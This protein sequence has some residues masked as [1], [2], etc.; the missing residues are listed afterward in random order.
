MKSNAKENHF[1]RQT[2]K[3]RSVSPCDFTFGQGL[4]HLSASLS[5][6]FNYTILLTSHPAV[7]RLIC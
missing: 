7:T 3:F 1:Q 2:K 6:T 4:V 5:A